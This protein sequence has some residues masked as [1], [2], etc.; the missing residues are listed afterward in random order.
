[1][2]PTTKINKQN[3]LFITFKIEDERSPRI[4]HNVEVKN[5]ASNLMPAEAK[6]ENDL[7]LTDQKPTPTSP[8]YFLFI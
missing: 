1:M 8:N 6:D 2:K 4:A 3:S 5:N 7:Q